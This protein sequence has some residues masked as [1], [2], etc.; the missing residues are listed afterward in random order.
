N[1]HS[2]VNEVTR[3][4]VLKSIDDLNYVP[5]N[6]AQSMR[7]RKYKNIAFLA[8]ISNPVFARIAKE[9]Q[10]E[11]EKKGYILYLGNIEKDNIQ[12]KITSFLAGRNFDGII[13][14]LPY[15]NDRNLNRMLSKLRI[16]IVL[17]NREISTLPE[18]VVIEYYTSVKKAINYLFKLG[19]T[20]ISLI[21]GSKKIR[22]TRESIKAYKKA[23]KKNNLSYE[24]SLI[25]S[26][27]LSS[28]AGE[29]IFNEMLPQIKENKI[30]A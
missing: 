27:D 20:N 12:Y 3:E 5:N 24:E 13:L 21:G 26:G 30:T 9:V 2:K 10:I 22:P 15:E 8:D 25:K 7:S 18:G 16:P 14:S 29:V 19:H 1:N 6:I 28:E 11:L 4:K 23:Y 17:I